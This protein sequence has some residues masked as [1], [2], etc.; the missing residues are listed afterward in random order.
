MGAGC[1]D[2]K[3]RLCECWGGKNHFLTPVHNWTR[4]CIREWHPVLDPLV[5]SKL[6]YEY[7]VTQSPPGSY[8]YIKWWDVGLVFASHAV[9]A[10]SE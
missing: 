2:T 8:I 10:N 4:N 3:T 1:I 6:E 5:G 9:K 7:S